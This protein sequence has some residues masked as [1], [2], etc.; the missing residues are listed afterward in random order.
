MCVKLALEDASG[1]SCRDCPICKTPTARLMVESL[2]GVGAV[3]EVERDL[4]ARVE[5]EVQKE[6]VKKQRGR[7]MM[8]S[9]EE[10]AHEL[11]LK[12]SDSLN[13]KCP[14]CSLVFHDYEGCNALKCSNS[15]C[16]AAFCAVCLMDCGNDAHPHARTHGGLFDKTLFEREKENREKATIEM[17]LSEHVDEPF[18]V[19]E[20]L[21]IK[22]EKLI[23]ISPTK[24]NQTAARTF[25]HNAKTSLREAVR[26]D[27]LSV[28]SDLDKAARVLT[29]DHISPRNAIPDDY[30]LCL[31]SGDGF[32]CRI[33]LSQ[34]IDGNWK[35]I[36]LPKEEDELKKPGNNRLVVDALINVRRSLQSCS[37]AF[38]GSRCLYQ[39][40]FARAGKGVE[41]AKDDEISMQFFRINSVTGEASGDGVA[42]DIIGCSGRRILGLNQ[43][44]RMLL[45]E[46]HV[47]GSEDD[48]L[49]FEPLLHFIGANKAAR[50]L[51]S[52]SVPAPDTFKELN[53]RQ[54]FVAHPLSIKTAME[55]AG[56]CPFLAPYYLRVPMRAMHRC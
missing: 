37:L 54:Q 22:C 52:L 53:N 5:L 15:G 27:R 55:C 43:N 42:L 31:F 20:L 4:R 45:L 35:V 12:L 46:Q 3:R 40:S 10:K 26:K 18:E 50:L 41:R 47:E 1:A 24:L 2:C 14:R 23:S 21:K 11:Y 56:T 33:V 13:M 7:E 28:L 51:E 32:K 17:F 38:E 39:T 25:L 6:N 8:S 16:Q 19:K 30:K 48:S 34:L 9:F 44:Q 49:L 36:P 29:S